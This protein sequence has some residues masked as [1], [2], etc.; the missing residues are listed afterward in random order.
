MTGHKERTLN[1]KINFSLK[2][3]NAQGSANNFFT[4]QG[5]K[6]SSSK[7]VEIPQ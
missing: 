7:V 1:G 2:K 4:Y 5:N 6:S 3:K